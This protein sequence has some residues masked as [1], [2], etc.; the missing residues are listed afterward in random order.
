MPPVTRTWTGATSG[1]FDETTNWLGG[2]IPLV[3]DHLVFDRGTRDLDSVTPGFALGN[4]VTTSGYKGRIAP[5]GSFNADCDSIRHGSGS[6][7]YNG[8]C[9]DVKINPTPGAKI[10]LVGGTWTEAFAERAD[11]SVQSSGVITTLRGRD[12]DLDDV[13]G[14]AYTLLEAAGASRIK[15][16]RG[17][18]IIVKSGSMADILDSAVLSA[19]SKAESAGVIRYLSDAEIAGLVEVE[20][21]GV[22]SA[23]E[24]ASAFAFSGTLGLWP[25]AIYDLNT[26]AG[27]V[28]PA[29]FKPYG[30]STSSNAG[31]PTPK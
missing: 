18:R 24:N 15:T 30:L 12:I 27:S 21:K 16:K 20:R 9:A 2:V 1:A 23:T 29:T 31:R 28:T 13:G 25:D 5:G 8:D 26:R 3:T 10:N 7:N 6:A 17:G 19:N 4:I 11:I 14:T 22:F